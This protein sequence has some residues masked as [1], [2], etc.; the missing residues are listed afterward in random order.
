MLAG[1]VPVLRRVAP[2]AAPAAGQRFAALAWPAFAVLVATGIWNIAAVG[3]AG[4]AYRTTLVV[5]LVAVLVSG[6]A[7]W[8]HAR[9]TDRRALALSGAL[10]GVAALVAL[11]LGVVLRG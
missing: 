3:P 10:S 2:E 6:A 11:L 9:A 8:A 4:G 7:A 5:K 1:L